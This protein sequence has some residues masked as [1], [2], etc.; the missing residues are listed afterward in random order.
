MIKEKNI[1]VYNVITSNKL[2]GAELLVNNLSISLNNYGIESYTIYGNLFHNKISSKNQI[3]LNLRNVRS[4]RFIFRLRKILKTEKNE[5]KVKILH[6]HLTWP[7]IY[8]LIASY[9]LN[10]KI[11]YTEHN[12]FNKRR[13]IPLGRFFDYFLYRNCH[14]IICISNNTKNA[15]LKWQHNL[16]DRK[17]IEVIHNGARKYK[18][19]S[20]NYY[21]NKGLH[22]ISIGSLTF[23]KGFDLSINSIPLISDQVDS[24]IILGEGEMRPKLEKLIKKQNLSSKVKLAGLQENIQPFLDQ[25]NLAIVPSRWEGFSLATIEMISAGLPLLINENYGGPKEVLRCKSVFSKDLS[26]SSKI[27]NSIRKIKSNLIKNNVNFS[28]ASSLAKKFSLDN[29]CR[30]Y[31][32]I[33]KSIS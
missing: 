13:N 14:R 26:S 11:I 25:A 2:G 32:D 17:K 8:G 31:A 7:L 30:S 21:K 33:Y 5:K 15:L 12:I 9:G 18:F 19:K 16:I 24:Y 10:Y 3:S 4:I 23:Q 6:L 1:L 22:L 20:R 27:A 28:E 29:F